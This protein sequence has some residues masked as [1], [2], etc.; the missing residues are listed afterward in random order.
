MDLESIVIAAKEFMDLTNALITKV[1]AEGNFL[2]LNNTSKK[3]FGLS[4]E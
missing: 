2:F 3:I 4:P 1:D